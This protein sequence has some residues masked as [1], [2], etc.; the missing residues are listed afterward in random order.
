MSGAS[1]IRQLSS[2]THGVKSPVNAVAKTRGTR[3]CLVLA[4]W[5]C[6]VPPGEWTVP[7]VGG[8]LPGNLFARLLVLPGPLV[9][10]FR[11]NLS[12]AQNPS[13]LISVGMLKTS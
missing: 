7:V 2:S 3:L 12:I 5:F 11:R 8:P 4:A 6:V 10:Y 1:P 13:E 9:C